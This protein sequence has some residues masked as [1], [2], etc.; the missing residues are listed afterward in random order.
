MI[1]YF[2]SCEWFLKFYRRNMGASIRPFAKGRSQPRTVLASFRSP[3]M[4]YL[5]VEGLDHR[6]KNMS[7]ERSRGIEKPEINTI[8]VRQK[9]KFLVEGSFL[10]FR[11]KKSVVFSPTQQP[12]NQKNSLFAPVS[13][14]ALASN[15]KR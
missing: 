1:S 11:E 8:K 14:R 5:Q 2:C 7:W 9:S 12:S 10:T 4:D 3:R 15:R 13:S 6:N